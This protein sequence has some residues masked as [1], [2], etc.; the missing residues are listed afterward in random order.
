MLEIDP[1]NIYLHIRVGYSICETDQI[2]NN[3][4]NYEYYVPN[5]NNKM[6][7]LISDQ[8]IYPNVQIFDM[9]ND[10][11]P[12]SAESITDRINNIRDPRFLTCRKKIYGKE[13]ENIMY[14][15]INKL[16]L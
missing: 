14:N 9:I 2:I 5:Q 13:M 16:V 1:N 6:Y 3:I 10:Y 12:L 7:R 4:S 8:L 15:G 11:G